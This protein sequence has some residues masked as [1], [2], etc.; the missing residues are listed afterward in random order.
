MPDAPQ[1]PESSNS[2]EFDKPDS[3]FEKDYQNF[4]LIAETVK[5]S[6]EQQVVKVPPDGYSWSGNTEFPFSWDFLVYESLK[7]KGFD[8]LFA[9]PTF[10]DVNDK[11]VPR[12]LAC[13]V[14]DR[15]K[16]SVLNIYDVL[17]RRINP[18]LASYFNLLAI[19]TTGDFSDYDFDESDATSVGSSKLG[20]ELRRK[21]VLQRAFLTAQLIRR[22]DVDRAQKY[23]PEDAQLYEQLREEGFTPLGLEELHGI[24]NTIID[25]VLQKYPE[26]RPQPEADRDS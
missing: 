24:A 3:Y 6:I 25:D 11:K 17:H 21:G 1:P 13:Y 22:Y 14:N 8:I 4:E 20:K 2:A 9:K 5:Y 7:E 18:R 12:L 16:Q 15:E 10:F 19:T 26:W 23:F